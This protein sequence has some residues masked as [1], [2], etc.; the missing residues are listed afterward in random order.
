M[1]R[2]FMKGQDVLVLFPMGNGKLLC[3]MGSRSDCHYEAPVGIDL[4]RS[5]D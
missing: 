4:S 1:P 5:I 3:I 2:Q